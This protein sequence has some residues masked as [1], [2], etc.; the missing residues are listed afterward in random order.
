M[1]YVWGT[2]TTSFGGAI[3]PVRVCS[4]LVLNFQLLHPFLLQTVIISQQEL[5]K[6]VQVWTEPLRICSVGRVQDCKALPC[7]LISPARVR[8][9]CWPSG[10]P[11]A[12][13]GLLCGAADPLKFNIAQL[14]QCLS[15][16]AHASGPGDL[17]S[18]SAEFALGF[19][20]TSA[21]RITIHAFARPCAH[22]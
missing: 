18:R 11:L 1:V 10:F 17:C 8:P 14:T 13:H 12:I 4:L 16:A 22:P 21:L 9:F 19:I 2:Q 6:L 7:T 5:G 15:V 20:A 3:T